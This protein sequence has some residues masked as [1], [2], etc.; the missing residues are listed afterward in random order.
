MKKSLGS[1]YEPIFYKLLPQTSNEALIDFAKASVS[2]LRKLEEQEPILCV[3]F[4]YPEQYGETKVGLT[5]TQVLDEM[6]EVVNR[7]IIDAYEKDNPQVDT[8]EA[9]IVMEKIALKM[10]DGYIPS[11][12]SLE[13]QNSAEY[14]QF[15]DWHIKF[16]ELILS[17]RDDVA[18]NVLRY[19]LS[20]K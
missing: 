17:E 5:P 9:T 12:S 19:A 15:C 20:P 6:N 8:Y 11:Y 2:G 4:I 16:Y 1:Y 13:M 3:K 10:G 7:V 18:G 14:K